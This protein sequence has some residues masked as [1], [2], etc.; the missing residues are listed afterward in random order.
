[1]TPYHNAIRLFRVAGVDVYLHWTWLVVA[2]FEIR[3]RDR[4]YT[5]LGWNVAE[6]LALFGIVLLHEF[7][8][9]LACRSVGGR[10]DRIVLWPL[11]GVAYVQPPPRPGALLWSIAAGPLVNVLLLPVT[12]GLFVFGQLAGWAETS[13]D[14]DHFL[15]AVSAMNIVL[16]VFNVLP[17]YP[18]DGG[19][20]LQALLWFVVG[21]ARSLQMV[22]VIGML[23]GAGLVVLAVAWQNWWLALICV[24]VVMQAWAGLQRARVLGRLAAAPRHADAACP[25]CGAAPLAGPFWR[26]G[27]CHTAFDPF[28]HRGACPRCGEASPRTACPNCGAAHPLAAW[29]QPAGAENPVDGQPPEG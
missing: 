11:G 17:I 3:L 15:F 14:L 22:S 18:L 12:V 1:M 20:I 8:H 7:G 27:R 26:C 29:Y 23:A 5:S 19:Q 4:D 10:A 2:F 13:P 9:A 24:F 6:Y 25:S 16:L 21:R 28:E